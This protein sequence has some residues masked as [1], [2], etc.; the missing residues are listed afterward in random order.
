MIEWKFK[1]IQSQFMNNNKQFFIAHFSFW[2]LIFKI[3]T[4]LEIFE[5]RNQL[6]FSLFHRTDFF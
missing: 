1:F 5:T 6:K 4:Q 3:W 2:Q